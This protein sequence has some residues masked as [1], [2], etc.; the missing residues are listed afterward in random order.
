MTT[1]DLTDI[2]AA[3]GPTV[4]SY[5][6]IGSLI[7][8]Y[9]SP[10]LV[11]KIFRGA[12]LEYLRAADLCF[13]CAHHLRK[14]NDE[15]LICLVQ[16][17]LGKF[18]CMK[19]K[20]LDLSRCR[21]LKGDAVIYC[22]KIMPNLE[23][24]SL[25]SAARFDVTEDFKVS[26]LETKSLQSVDVS[27]CTRLGTQEISCIAT[28]LSVGNIRTLDLS[29]CSTLIG[30][31][32]AVSVARHCP[33]LECVNIS[34]SKKITTF[35]VAIIAFVRRRS[36]R[37]LSLRGC[38]SVKLSVL[39]YNQ[40][41]ALANELMIWRESGHDYLSLL[42]RMTGSSD[43]NACLTISYAEALANSLLPLAYGQ[44]NSRWQ[45]ESDRVIGLCK[46]YERQW[47]SHYGWETTD[48]TPLFGR[49]EN[50]DLS[51]AN[52]NYMGDDSRALAMISWLNKG[53]IRQLS[54]CGSRD[55]I[56]ALALASGS[57]LQCLEISYNG[58]LD[59]PMQSLALFTL[60]GVSEL[61][62]SCCDAFINNTTTFQEMES[63]RCL[64]L[65][66]LPIKDH[67]LEPFLLSTKR[68]LRLSVHGCTSLKMSVLQ[69]AKSQNS[70]LK[71]LDID[72][73]DVSMDVPLSR[74]RDS[75]PTLLKLNN[76]CTKRG[77]NMI[78][79]HQRNYHWRIGAR[80]R[81]CGGPS[82]RKRG[83]HMDMNQ[84]SVAG[85]NSSLDCCSI[86]STGFSK[87]D[88][89][90]QEMFGC[91]TCLIEFGRFVCFHC[92][93]ICHKSLGHEVHSVGYGPGYCDCSILSDCMCIEQH[94]I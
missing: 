31:E 22:L 49:L 15:Q 52:L 82:K 43:E 57:R 77:T 3:V 27:G 12:I 73:R 56:S 83:E 13:S 54:T 25:S 19:T 84:N 44:I 62:L 4:F 76:R 72:A 41:L 74:I 32:A 61:D 80:E 66:H 93:T 60:R 45:E 14:I 64:K 55:V 1:S 20:R 86:L 94:L 78:L 37:C 26:T 50:L 24:I 47:A 6:P 59:R 58:R 34:G 40:A 28:K 48:E 92:A 71:L 9:T 29:F 91:K 81:C 75:F 89:T 38:T 39:L 10:L 85:A 23:S 16:T 70:D 8:G 87:V 67:N 65:D 51:H 90:E 33:N 2:I 88:S 18:N 68:L 36:L 46:E 53:Q 17:I 79:Q 35:G 21:K 5:L 69:K 42:C 7:N 30:D 11:N 63:L